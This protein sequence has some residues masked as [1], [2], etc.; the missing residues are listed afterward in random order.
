MA[1]QSPEYKCTTCGAVFVDEDTFAKH[2]LVHDASNTDAAKVN[3]PVQDAS[4]ISPAPTT[5]PQA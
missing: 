1:T 5:T 3:N 2:N 4:W